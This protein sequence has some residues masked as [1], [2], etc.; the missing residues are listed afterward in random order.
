MAECLQGLK[1]VL[2][3]ADGVGQV[4]LEASGEV[5]PQAGRTQLLSLQAG[6]IESVD[7][8]LGNGPH[9]HR[10]SNAGPSNG[11][12]IRGVAAA[13][14]PGEV[15]VGFPAT[16][17]SANLWCLRSSTTSRKPV[18][19]VCYG[20]WTL[21]EKQE[22][23]GGKTLPSSGTMRAQRKTGASVLMGELVSPL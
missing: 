4:E 14:G 17:K 19:I 16:T 12:R 2:L 11:R 5:V 3:A 13:A 18:G 6:H 15:R 23:P 10:R 7:S 1:I 9:V 21:L 8:E 20:A 22:W